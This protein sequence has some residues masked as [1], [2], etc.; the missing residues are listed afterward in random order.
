MI[1]DQNKQELLHYQPGQPVLSVYLNTDPAEGNA[2]FHRR[3]LRSMLKD[4]PLPADVEAIIEFL[5]HKHDWSGKSTAMFSCSGDG[6]FRAYPIAM[7]IRSRMVIGD[8]PYIK[9][10]A[11]LLDLYGG[12]GVV[13]I[14]KQGARYFHF[15]LGELQE[16]D[17]VVGESIRHTKRGGGSQAAGRRGGIAGQT[18]YVDETTERNMRESAGHAIRFFAEKN[19]RRILI[20]GTD[21]NVA[22]FRNF[23]PKAWQSLVVGSF[24]ISMTASHNEVLEKAMEIGRQAEKQREIHL[25]ESIV[26][27]AA[28]GRGGVVGLQNTLDAIREGRVQTLVIRDG[29]REAGRQCT[30]CG[31]ITVE[32]RETCIYCSGTTE[33]IADVVEVAVRQEMGVGG[34]V[35]VLHA[36]QVIQG[37]DKIG[38]IL[39]Y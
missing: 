2:D 35:E 38:A 27:N 23:L 8:R 6:F 33:K 15:H 17:G 4:V 14:D 26:T 18:A 3:N 24:P 19:V 39:R 32:P 29:Y 20:G 7:P 12:Y 11:D 1:T 36:D 31:Y 30:S 34:E 9:P 5:E 16:Q 21:D 10:I 25:V 28:K 22:M 37:F 13:V